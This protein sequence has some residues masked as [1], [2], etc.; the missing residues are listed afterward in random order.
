MNNLFCDKIFKIN[1]ISLNN[2]TIVSSTQKIKTS[3]WQYNF[4]NLKHTF[5]KEKHLEQFLWERFISYKI[6]NKTDL[7]EQSN[8][9]FPEKIEK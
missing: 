5:Q 6:E 4:T 2:S 7:N 3:I 9:Y 8:I 1:N